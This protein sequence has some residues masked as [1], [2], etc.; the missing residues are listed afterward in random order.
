[1]SL[2][3]GCAD[4]A[5][6]TLVNCRPGGL[7]AQ[8]LVPNSFKNLPKDA[9][10]AQGSE[11]KRFLAYYARVR[12]ELSAQYRPRAVKPD[13]YVFIRDAQSLCGFGRTHF[14]DVT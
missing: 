9:V 6:S 5:A 2:R 12:V 14:F 4:I 10:A 7:V 13:L 8:V 3:A 1:M 11:G